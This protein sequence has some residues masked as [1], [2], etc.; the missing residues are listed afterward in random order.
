MSGMCAPWMHSKQFGACRSEN[1]SFISKWNFPLPVVVVFVA[2]FSLVYLLLETRIA[3]DEIREYEFHLSVF[4]YGV[5]GKIEKVYR[6]MQII[7]YYSN[8]TVMF[9]GICW[10]FIKIERFFLLFLSLPFISFPSND[11]PGLSELG[12][13]PKGDEQQ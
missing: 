3:T 13:L 12:R 8:E 9:M 11:R 4:A 5:L 1:N 6:Q 7:F 10:I 2:E